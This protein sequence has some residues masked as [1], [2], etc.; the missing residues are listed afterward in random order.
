MDR[1]GPHA[2]E[3]AFSIMARVSLVIPVGR[4]GPP[5]PARLAPI[6][7]AL[8]SAGHLVEVLIAAEPD[9]TP[10]AD[11]WDH[12]WTWIAVTDKGRAAAALAG[13]ERATGDIL[14][15]LDPERGY[16]AADILRVVDSLAAGK[17]G[18]VIGS[19]VAPAVDAGSVGRIRA[20]IGSIARTVTG[21]SDPLSGLIGLRRE[22]LDATGS[23]FMAV[24]S[25]FSLELLAKMETPRVDV[26]A[27]P[28]KA[29]R[30]DWPGLDDLRHFK[31]L[32][33]HR[34]GNFSRLFQ[35]CAVGASGMVVDLTLYAAFQWLFALTPLAGRTAPI[36]GSLD[37]AAAG[38]LAVAIALC[39]NF[40][41]NRRLTFSYARRGSIVGQFL[42]YVASNAL[43]V[44][45]NLALRLT[46]PRYIDFFNQHRLAA[47]L[48]GIVLATGISFS[49]SRWVVFRHRAQPAVRPTPLDASTV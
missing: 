2:Y 39:W 47:A 24:G 45:L 28:E 29:T 8:T 48:V 38:F 5:L 19:R 31:R 11:A 27:R 46:L 33:D 4:E 16:L 32:A 13:L 15:A 12:S 7:L 42:A 44:S 49:M 37:L 36:V 10:A 35:F 26:A 43:A 30:R 41:L 3:G 40:S 20:A 17:R 21:T 25:H 34:F 6:S 14:V 9:V 18:L 1:D 22:T 23:S